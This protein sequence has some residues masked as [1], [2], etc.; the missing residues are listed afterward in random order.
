MSGFRMSKIAAPSKPMRTGD[1]A[2]T[3]HFAGVLKGKPE[4]HRSW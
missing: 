4:F 2:N 1:V 3:A